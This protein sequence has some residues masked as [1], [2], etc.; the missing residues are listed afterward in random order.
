MD[1]IEEGVRE[2]EIRDDLSPQIMRQVILGSIENV[3]LTSVVFNRDISPDDLTE[4]LCE[5][6]FKGIALNA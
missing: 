2:G 4:E 6:V 1:I 3:C 5:F